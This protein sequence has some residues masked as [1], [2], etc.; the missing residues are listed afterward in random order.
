MNLKTFGDHKFLLNYQMNRRVLFGISASIGGANSLTFRVITFA[1]YEI[2]FL[3]L[4][5]I[6]MLL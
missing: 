4:K 5:L 3:N 1:R 6:N 2:K